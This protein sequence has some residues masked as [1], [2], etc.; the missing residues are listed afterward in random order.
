MW[1]RL[2]EFVKRRRLDQDLDD[3]IGFHLD[4]LAEEHRARGWPEKEARERARRDFGGITQLR[5]AHRDLRGIPFVESCAQD[6]RFAWR[7]LRKDSAFLVIALLTLTIGIGANVAMLTV[8]NAVILQ[9]LPVP[10]PERLMALL[11]SDEAGARTFHSAPGVYL[12]WRER[13]TSFEHIEGAA[14]TSMT[15]SG[16]GQPHRAA[17]IR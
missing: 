15:L 17:Y 2:R 13:S 5:E 16:A 1:H 8:M 12:D 11:S 3:E 9:P 4:M 10:N 7:S 6:F 14:I